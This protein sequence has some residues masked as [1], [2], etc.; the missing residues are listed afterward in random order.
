M[1]ETAHIPLSQLK[2]IIVDC[3]HKTEWVYFAI[4]FSE[5]LSWNTIAK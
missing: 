3:R 1:H 2:A 5:V 4:L